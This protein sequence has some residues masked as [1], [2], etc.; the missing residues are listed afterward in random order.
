MLLPTLACFELH[1]AR[2]GLISAELGQM[3]PQFGEFV[4][5]LGPYL[6]QHFPNFSLTNFHQVVPNIAW[7]WSTLANFDQIWPDLA[8][9]CEYRP[10][11]DQ[12][13][14]K[15][16]YRPKGRRYSNQ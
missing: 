14:P 6:S 9:A 7:I 13:G 11:L 5:I 2:F 16:S 10:K 3:I 15:P 1:L 4:L 12:I 8:N